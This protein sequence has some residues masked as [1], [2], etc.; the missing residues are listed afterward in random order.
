LLISLGLVLFGGS[1]R[2]GLT[3]WDDDIYITRNA[4]IQDP[5]PAGVWR[6]FTTFSSCNYHPLTLLSYMAEFAVAGPDPWLYHLSNVLLHIAA[7]ILAYHLARAWSGSEPA[8]LL[9][10]L[11]FLAH[12]LRVECVAWAA[13]RKDLLCGVFYLGA[14]LAYTRHVERPSPARWSAALVLSVLALLSKVMAITIPAALLLLLVARRKLDRRRLLEVAPFAA[15]AALFAWLGFLAQA[16]DGGVKGLHGAGLL[17]HLLTVPKALTFYGEKLIWPFRLSPRYVI[18]PARGPGDAAAIAGIALAALG[19]LAAAWSFRGR[20]VVFLG[21]TFFAAALAPVSG[22]V[23]S[24]TIAADR[25]LYLPAFG[26]FLAFAAAAAS[27]TASQRLL[28]RRAGWAGIAV[29]GSFLLACSFLTPARA[30]V[31][32][33]DATLWAD[34]LLENAR[35]PFAHHQLALAR[36]LDG[37]YAVALAHATRSAEL[38]LREPGQLQRIAVAARG[39]G[40]RRREAEAAR[41]I[42]DLDPSFPPAAAIL[43]RH[44]REAGGLEECERILAAAWDSH[45]EDPDLLLERGALEEAR[46]NLQGALLL[47]LR[48]IEIR[49]GDAEALLSASAILLRMGDPTRAFGAAERTVGLPGFALLPGPAEALGKLVEAA[50]ASGRADWIARAKEIAERARGQTGR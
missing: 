37:D 29:A 42:L 16:A 1:I 13:G 2:N 6:I 5:S 43:A 25:Y 12:P 36:M 30:A 23:P 24:S 40:D 50:R 26:L 41:A 46:G 7:S 49:G 34:A 4:L 18:E 47:D 17:P 14:L 31:W 27:A 8:A 38:G 10:A 45:P 19:V 35:N 44:A 22:I 9:A 11:L 3:S 28:A 48:A 33:S 32:R 15:I 21:L 39:L 20:R